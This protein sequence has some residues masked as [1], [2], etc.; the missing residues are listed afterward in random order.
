MSLRYALVVTYE[1][2]MTSVLSFPRFRTLDYFKGITLRALGAKVGKRVI[3]YPGAWIM[4]ANRL[5]L[6]DDV[7]VARHV[8]IA[9]SAP[10][11]IGARSLL[12]YGA[13]IISSNHNVHTAERIFDSGHVSASI[14]I[15]P[16]VWIG[17]NAVVLPGV[18]I[19]TGAVVGAG[20]VVTKNVDAYAI[21]GG[22]PARVIGQR[23]EASA[24]SHGSSTGTFLQ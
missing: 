13:R 20:S 23:T 15:A 3:F 22:V 16:D 4:P 10:V 17:T 19:G 14:V 1:T 2:I 5:T 11:S 24:R 6:G 12:G 7:D 8:I 9:G 18:T 21:V